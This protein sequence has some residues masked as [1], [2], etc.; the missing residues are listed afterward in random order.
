MNNN[1][2]LPPEV[3]GVEANVTPLRPTADDIRARIAGR[4]GQR[5]T[6]GGALP[7]ATPQDDPLDFEVGVVA[8]DGTLTVLNYTGFMVA[9]SV[10]VGFADEVGLLQ[11]IVPMDRLVYVTPAEE[12]EVAFEPEVEPA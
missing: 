12:L 6:F 11:G 8:P 4:E 2:D 1:N 5:T 9:T 7:S 10:F 3:S